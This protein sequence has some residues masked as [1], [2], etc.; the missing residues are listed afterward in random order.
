MLLCQF[1]CLLDDVLARLADVAQ[2][3]IEAQAETYHA[4]VEEGAD[5]YQQTCDDVEPLLA[6]GACVGTYGEDGQVVELAQYESVSRIA[7]VFDDRFET[8]ADMLDILIVACIQ[9]NSLWFSL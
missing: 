4:Y 6:E 1:L 2:V 7:Q 3:A 8:L 9:R 5:G